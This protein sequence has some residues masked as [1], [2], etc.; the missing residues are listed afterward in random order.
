M[1]EAVK[2]ASVKP[3]AEVQREIEQSLIEQ[4]K[5][6]AQERWVQGLRDKAYIKIL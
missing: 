4:E 5:L 1:V 3:Y 2:K 6:K